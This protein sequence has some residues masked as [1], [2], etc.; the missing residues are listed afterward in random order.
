[1]EINFFLPKCCFS[2]F[3]D[4]Y[5][6]VCLQKIFLR[7]YNEFNSPGINLINNNFLI[8]VSTVKIVSVRHNFTM[9]YCNFGISVVKINLSQTIVRILISFY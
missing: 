6:F 3:L 2:R 4:L 8:F 7:S 9:N 5:F 1:M